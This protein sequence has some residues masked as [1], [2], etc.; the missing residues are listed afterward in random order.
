[1]VSWPYLGT[2]ARISNFCDVRDFSE[3]KTILVIGGGFGY[4]VHTLLSFF[5]SITKCITVDIPPYLYV[6][7]QYLKAIYGESVVDYADVAARPGIISMSSAD[8]REIL[9]IAP[10]QLDRI[11]ASVD[12]LWNSCSFVEMTVPQVKNY[13]S[14]AERLLRTSAQP[15]V[16]IVSY[17]T[18]MKTRQEDVLSAFPAFRF[19][20]VDVTRRVMPEE[21]YRECQY[22]G[23]MS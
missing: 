7:T 8:K 18:E 13:A 22:L 23:S 5:P 9:A 6:Q 14:V 15:T 17:D 12:L 21:C 19:T 1:M 4:E 20:K 10:W 11:D 2:Y 3:F 16:C